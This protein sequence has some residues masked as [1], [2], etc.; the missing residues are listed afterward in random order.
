MAYS[1]TSYYDSII[2]RHIRSG[3]ATSKTEVMHQALELLDA[4]TRGRGPVGSTIGTV[5][6]LEEMLIA[7]LDSVPAKPMTDADWNA[8]RKRI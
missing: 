6:E 2:E 8:L 3:R 7:G 5:E 1:Q 4:V